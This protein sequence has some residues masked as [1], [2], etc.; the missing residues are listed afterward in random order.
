MNAETFLN[1]VNPKQ[2]DKIKIRLGYI[3]ANYSSGLPKIAFDSDIDPATGIAQPSGK[4]Y[5]H[6]A[7]Y[8]PTAGDRV[9]LINNLIIGKVVNS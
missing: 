3:D 8:T 7:S 9:I 5:S 2:Q 4:T 1:I 6:L